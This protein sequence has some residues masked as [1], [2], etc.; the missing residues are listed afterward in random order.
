MER[1]E[2]EEIERVET[3]VSEGERKSVWKEKGEKGG[4]TRKKI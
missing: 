2:M 1:K 3:G 4:V